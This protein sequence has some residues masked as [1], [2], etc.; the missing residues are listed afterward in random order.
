V[1][2]ATRPENLL[3]DSLVSTVARFHHPIKNKNMIKQV[4]Y[5]MYKKNVI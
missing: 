5:I 2:S 1:H 4:T 3:S